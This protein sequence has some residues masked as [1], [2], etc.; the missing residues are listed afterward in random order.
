MYLLGMMQQYHFKMFI[1]M[2]WSLLL[3]NIDK[4]NFVIPTGKN[5]A[6]LLFRRDAIKLIDERYILVRECQKESNHIGCERM[7]LLLCY[8][9]ITNFKSGKTIY[10]IWGRKMSNI[11]G[12]KCDWAQNYC[13]IPLQVKCLYTTCIIRQTTR[14]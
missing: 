11:E 7:T 2:A 8:S 1:F 4:C 13:P 3:L 10:F 5:I 9:S 12:N 6:P 14:N